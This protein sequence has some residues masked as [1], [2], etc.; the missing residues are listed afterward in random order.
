MQLVGKIGY[1]SNTE[2]IKNDLT[3]I[4]VYDNKELKGNLIKY[5]INGSKIN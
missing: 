1:I 4:Y 5:D 3:G 2:N